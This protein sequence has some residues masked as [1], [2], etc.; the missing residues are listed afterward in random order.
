MKICHNLIA[1]TAKEIAFTCY[2]YLAGGSDDFYRKFP[3]SRRFVAKHWRDFVGHARA[4]LTVLLNPIPGTEKDPD[5][6]KYK[7]PEIARDEIYEALITEGAY[8]HVPQPKTLYPA[9]L[10]RHGSLH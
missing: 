4:S 8:K 9:D 6:P 5:G 2:E 10:V 7:L 3:T 1:K